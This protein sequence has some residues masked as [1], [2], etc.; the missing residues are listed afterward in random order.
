MIEPYY[1]NDF[2]T[3][4]YGDCL[5]VLPEI[6]FVFDAVIT[7]PPY[8]NGKTACKWDAVIPFEPMWKMIWNHIKTNGAVCLFSNEPFTSKLICSNLD[9]FRYRWNWKK[10]SGGAFQLAKVQPMS[11]VEDICVFS[12][13]RCA[14]GDNNPMVYYPIMT[15]REKVDYRTGGKAVKSDMLNDSNM[16]ALNKT[17]THKYPTTVLEFN[18]P[19][20]TK[21]IHPTE[22]PVDLL[23]YLIKTYTKE[24]EIILDFCSGSGSI[25]EACMNT[26]R[27]CLLIEKEK[28]YCDLTVSRLKDVEKVKS[29]NLF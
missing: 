10:E 19:C 18:K 29:E 11:V 22:K 12:K 17:Y 3:L 1:K 25:G 15:Q 24:N 6:D 28:G 2:V 21:R 8:G 5:S 20:G 9:G 23:E 16:I 14:N 7:D 13:G 26:N 4:Y 27:K